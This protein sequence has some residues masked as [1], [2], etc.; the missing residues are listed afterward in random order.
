MK[1][2]LFF[3]GKRIQAVKHLS[4]GLG[5]QYTVIEKSADGK[6]I[7]TSIHSTDV[8]RNPELQSLFEA[9]QVAFNVEP[10]L[11]KNTRQSGQY[12]G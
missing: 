11:G 12:V 1:R 5:E 4:S 7:F 9:C 2:T 10:S 3:K 8:A 6:E